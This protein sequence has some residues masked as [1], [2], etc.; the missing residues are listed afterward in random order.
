MD[1]EANVVVSPDLGMLCTISTA[2]W[3]RRSI[4]GLSTA[5]ADHTHNTHSHTYNTIVINSEQ[6]REPV[7]GEKIAAP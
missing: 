1:E 4:D 7:G 5:I 2:A 6:T 3:N